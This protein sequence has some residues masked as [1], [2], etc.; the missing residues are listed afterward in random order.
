VPPDHTSRQPTA[1]DSSVC[2][3]CQSVFTPSPR[4]PRQR[5][6]STSCRQAAWRRRQQQPPPPAAPADHSQPEP[7]P[8]AIHAC[9]HCGTPIAVVALLVTPQAA[10]PYPKTSSEVIAIQPH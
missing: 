8:V 2:P 4:Q 1:A 5:Y 7:H 3:V 9:P 6:C 10:R